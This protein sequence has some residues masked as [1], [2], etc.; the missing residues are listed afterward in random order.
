MA[1]VGIQDPAAE[2]PALPDYMLDPN[3]VLGDNSAE[4]RYGRA[5]D[6][7]NTRKVYEQSRYIYIQ[8]V[9]LETSCYS[10]MPAVTSHSFEESPTDFALQQKPKATPRAVFPPSLRIWS[11]IGRLKPASKPP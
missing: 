7:S 5:P 2:A 8:V 3:A 11:R 10:A 1:E 6:Y 4:W 9:L